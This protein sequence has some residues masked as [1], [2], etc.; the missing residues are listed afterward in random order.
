MAPRPDVSE[1]RRRQILDAAIK[2]FSEAGF[3]KARMDDIVSESG[4]SKGT[5]YWYFDSK[6]AIITAILEN[7]FEGEICHLQGLVDTPG[8]ATERLGMFMN[9][10]IAEFGHIVQT[11]PLTFEFYAMALR[12]DVIREAMRG[13]FD[14]Y[15]KILIPII[16]Q[17][18]QSGEFR[19][20]DAFESSVALGALMEG[21]IL[22]WVIDPTSISIEKH[23]N[24]GV[25]PVPA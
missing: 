5:L 4:L 24:S 9:S 14:A 19:K 7:I 10:T 1:E 16:E 8:S 13:Y 3:D 6:D 20:V 21:T 11:L 22:L 23:L 15:L 12:N 25:A 2:V 18:I 17:G